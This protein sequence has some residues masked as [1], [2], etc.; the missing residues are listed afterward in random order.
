MHGEVDTDVDLHSRP[1]YLNAQYFTT[2]EIGTPPQE[3]KVMSV[4]LRFLVF[5]SAPGLTL[6][7]RQSR[8]WLVQSLGCVTGQ[9]SPDRE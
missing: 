7:V 6:T 5:A 1:D 9:K 3:F 4:P 8:H 2:I